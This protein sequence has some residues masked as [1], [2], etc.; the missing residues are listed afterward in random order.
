[1]D[2]LTRA[3]IDRS[4]LLRPFSLTTSNF[5]EKNLTYIKKNRGIFSALNMVKAIRVHEVGGTEVGLDLSFALFPRL[6]F[7]YASFHY[8]RSSSLKMLR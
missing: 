4:P 8:I 1:M 7:N 6:K 3:V 2:G 5:R